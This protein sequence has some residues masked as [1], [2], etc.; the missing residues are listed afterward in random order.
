MGW[1]ES[2]TV[3]KPRPLHRY[4]VTSSLDRSV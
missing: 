3:T 1:D 2:E 4:L